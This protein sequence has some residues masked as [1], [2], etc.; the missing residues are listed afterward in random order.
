MCCS[1]LQCV[2]Q[3][4]CGAVLCSVVQCGVACYCGR[5]IC[6][7]DMDYSFLNNFSYLDCGRLICMC[8]MDYSFLNNF[9]YLDT[10]YA[11]ICDMTDSC[12]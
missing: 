5:L 12:V 11:Y 10:T 2:L 1:V 8:D 6:M 4:Q 7:C 9:S 3:L